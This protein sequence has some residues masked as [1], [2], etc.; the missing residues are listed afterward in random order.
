VRD[1]AMPDAHT[2]AVPLM[3]A[4]ALYFTLRTL[5]G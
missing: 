5:R 1:P 2:V 3:I 4:I